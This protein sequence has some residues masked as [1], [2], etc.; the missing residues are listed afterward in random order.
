MCTQLR[1]VYISLNIKHSVPQIVVIVICF[2][3]QITCN[4]YPCIITVL[5]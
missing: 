2:T 3:D 4:F 1:C 5:R